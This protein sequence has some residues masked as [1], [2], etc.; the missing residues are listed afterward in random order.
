MKTAESKYCAHCG[1]KL[2]KTLVSAK[3]CFTIWGSSFTE[4]NV[5]TGKKQYVYKYAC[6]EFK[7]GL[8]RTFF[9]ES[10]HSY[11]FD[12]TIRTFKHNK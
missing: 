11:F 5:E 2:I 1:K 8:L 4:Y 9:C 3:E 7:E 6:P 10:K 12:L